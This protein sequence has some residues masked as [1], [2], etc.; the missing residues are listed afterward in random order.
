VIV[1]QSAQLLGV[2]I[3]D[4][5]AA[6]IAGRCR[7]T[8]RI[9]NRLLRRVRDYAEVKVD[10]RITRPVAMAAL[11]MMDV[12]T[13]GFD[14]IDRKLM[15]T[16]ID[17]RGHLRTLPDPGRFPGSHAARQDGHKK[18]L[19]TLPHHAKKQPEEPILKGGTCPA[20]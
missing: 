14:D 8:P 7:G 20:P 19:R 6:E 13:Y 10:G 18:S 16:I 1:R 3:D 4:E 5:G 9:A 17:H 2:D 11:A 15:L 12:D